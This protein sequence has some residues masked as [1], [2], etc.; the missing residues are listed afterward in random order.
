MREEKENK[1]GKMEK[2]ACVS[3]EQEGLNEDREWGKEKLKRH[4]QVQKP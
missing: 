4:I 1:T 2:K 3:K